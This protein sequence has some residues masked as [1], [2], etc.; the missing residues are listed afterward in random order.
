M[1]A[2]MAA[3]WT[4]HELQILHKA[5]LFASISLIE[6][7][8]QVLR[9]IFALFLLH[10]LPGNMLWKAALCYTAPIASQ[11]GICHHMLGLFGPLRA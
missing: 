5:V 3:K 8:I 1:R 10:A 2:L 4:V 6:C 11:K 9:P 7:F